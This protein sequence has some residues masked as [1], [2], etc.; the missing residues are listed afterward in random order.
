MKDRPTWDVLKEVAFVSLDELVNRIV[1]NPDELPLEIIVAEIKDT[2]ANNI[3]AARNKHR[4]IKQ[5]NIHNYIH[6]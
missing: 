2:I 1:N 6:K 5:R 3:K 4:I